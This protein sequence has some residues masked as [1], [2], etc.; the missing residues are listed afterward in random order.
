MTVEGV[1]ERNACRADTTGTGQLLIVLPALNEEDSVG[2]VIREVRLACTDYDVLVVDDGSVDATAARAA[3]AGADVMRLPFNLGVGGAMRAAYRY[4]RD[5]G[6]S[7]VVQVD[8]DGQHDPREIAHLLA[9][10]GADL[11]IGA[12]F[13]G[14]GEYVVRG[15]RRWAMRLLSSVLSRIVGTRLTDP[16]SGFRLVHG[17]ALALF[18]EHYPE[19][20]LGDTVESLVIAHRAGM[21][22]SQVPV[23]MR[24]RETGV[25]SQNPFRAA[26]YLFRVV[27]AVALA[28]VRRA[29]TAGRE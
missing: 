10:A 3:A 19:E 1:E 26:M 18:A 27:I 9:V 12:R 14:R 29:P 24:A 15:P 2:R 16:T 4:A 5:Q 21:V 8:A 6:Y 22:V 20:Y 28:L 23:T 7:S 13:A 25:A 11:V 17:R